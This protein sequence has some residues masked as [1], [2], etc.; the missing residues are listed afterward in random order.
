MCSVEES[1]VAIQEDKRVDSYVTS[2]HADQQNLHNSYK[3]NVHKTSTF[4]AVYISKR[5]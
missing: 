4:A 1:A 2:R 3:M 5:T